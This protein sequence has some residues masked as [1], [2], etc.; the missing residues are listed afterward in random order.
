M[1]PYQIT[2]S[3]IDEFNEKGYLILKN[4]LPSE[5]LAEL[6]ASLSNISTNAIASYGTGKILPNTSY[7]EENGKPILT[8]ANNLI[9]H[10]PETILDM[11]A[12]PAMMPI[13]R[14]LSG[15]GTIPIQCDALFK[16]PHPESVVKWHQDALHSRNFPYL[17]IGVYLDD[18]NVGDGC[19]IYVKGSQHEKLKISELVKKYDWEIPNAEEIPA[20]AGDILIQDMMVLHASRIKKADGVRRTIY[21]EMR[22]EE[23]EIEQNVHITKWIEA[24][25]GWMG[26]IL[27]RS[28]ISWPEDTHGRFPDDLKSD[29]EEIASLLSIQESA[30]PANYGYDLN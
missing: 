25:K 10:I 27:R 15:P 2:P 1:S 18:A 7:I 23:A 9:G 14:D 30:I 21:V 13:A 22:P 17:N 8:R 24:R 19:L 11:F 5:L 3:Q 12:C 26:I 6:Q 29:E 28:K 4:A 20:E 16:H